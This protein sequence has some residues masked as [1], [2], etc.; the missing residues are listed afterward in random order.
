MSNV[1][2]LF[3]ERDASLK[4]EVT[5][6]VNHV[7]DSGIALEYAMQLVIA[8]SA[9]ADSVHTLDETARND[10]IAKLNKTISR[11]TE[12]EIVFLTTIVKVVAMSLTIEEFEAA[13]TNEV[14]RRQN[15]I[16]N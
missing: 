10:V 6:L 8:L 13:I 14:L 2:Q 11:T 9:I 15:L 1:T 16:D 4:A 5:H 3:N 12:A 7:V